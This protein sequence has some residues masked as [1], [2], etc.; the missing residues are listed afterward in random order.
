MDDRPRVTRHFYLTASEDERLRVL[1][2]RSRRSVNDIVVEA[3]ARTLA[4]VKAQ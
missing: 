3:L 2:F 4:D 1:A